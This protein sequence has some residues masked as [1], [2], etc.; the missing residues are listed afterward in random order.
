MFGSSAMS[1]CVESGIIT[2]RPFSGVMIMVRNELRKFTQTVIS[3]ERYAI[4][5]IGDYLLVDVYS[6]RA[7]TKDIQ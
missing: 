4:I 1:K 7:G 6:P 5:K 3:D 2:G